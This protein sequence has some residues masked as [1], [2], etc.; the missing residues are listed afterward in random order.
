M[1]ALWRRKLGRPSFRSSY[2][3]SRQLWLPL[4]RPRAW[5]TAQSHSENEITLSNTNGLTAST[6]AVSFF[7]FYLPVIHFRWD[8][9]EKAKKGRLPRWNKRVASVMT[10]I[11]SMPRFL[12][13]KAQFLPKLLVLCCIWDNFACFFAPTFGLITLHEAI[14][15]S[16]PRFTVWSHQ[17]RLS[18]A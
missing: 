12:V 9:R 17:M 8:F 11:E 13:E 6:S 10:I 4:E 5:A 1:K 14:R 15:T 2:Q 3:S 7:V 16:R 18:S